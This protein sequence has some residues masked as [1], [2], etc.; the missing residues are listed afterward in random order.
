M[1]PGWRFVRGRRVGEGA[2]RQHR[3]A[4]AAGRHPRRLVRLGPAVH[5]LRIEQRAQ[6]PFEAAQQGRRPRIPGRREV[7]AL[8]RVVIGAPF[9]LPVIE[10]TL[11]REQRQALADIMMQRVADLLP[12][13][14]QGHYRPK[15]ASRAE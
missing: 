10:G 5:R 11:G 13:A 7:V 8:L 14:Y 1:A 4:A 15:V 3:G 12:E 6:F 9:S 2:A